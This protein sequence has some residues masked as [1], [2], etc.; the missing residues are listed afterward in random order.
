MATKSSSVYAHSESQGEP[1]RGR[2]FFAR[3]RKTYTGYRSYYYYSFF[4]VAI[5]CF[6]YDWA[7]VTMTR[8]I[9][10]LRALFF[11]GNFVTW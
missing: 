11:K 3:P 5:C 6:G 10:S 8:L 4:A 7:A 9:T 2:Q 1:N